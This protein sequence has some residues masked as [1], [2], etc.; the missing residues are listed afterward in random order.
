MARRSPVDRWRDRD[1]RE[2]NDVV[3]GARSAG[4]RGTCSWF[5]GNRRHRRWRVA[6]S[7]PGARHHSG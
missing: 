6:G 2:D 4:R 7:E 3:D 5:G 1:R